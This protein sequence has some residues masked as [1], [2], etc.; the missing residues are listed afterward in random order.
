MIEN[1]HQSLIQ[2][3]EYLKAI[4]PALNKNCLRKKFKKETEEH[5]FLLVMLQVMRSNSLAR[6][7]PESRLD[8]TTMP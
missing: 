8:F 6:P 5:N 7:S 1:Y 2:Q 3:S 4:I